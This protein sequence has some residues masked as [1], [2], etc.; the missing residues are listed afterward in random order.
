MTIKY[1]EAEYQ[2]A[3][4]N[5]FLKLQCENKRCNSIFLKK[6]KY[7]NQFFSGKEPT[8]CRFCARRC[9][10]KGNPPKKVKCLTCNSSFYKKP[11]EMKK[12][13]NDFCSRSCAATYNNKNKK[14]G[15][16]R[17]KFEIY[18]EKILNK[19]Y[20]SLEILYNKKK[21]IGSELDIYI[22][23]FKLAIE[24]SGIFHFKPIYGRK[25]FDQIKANDLLKQQKCEAK[26]ISLCVVDISKISY[27]VNKNFIPKVNEIID[28]INKY[29][30]KHEIGISHPPKS[31][32]GALTS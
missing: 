1:T 16:R 24:I 7:I 22:P 30:S 11:A 4:S 28:I 9:M 15:T 3:K 21:T 12:G 13:N 18:C 20:P 25:K 14:S 23:Q 17:S 27:C 8:S 5:D 10:V 26:N 2:N 32:F 29:N 6:K 31:Q 19:K